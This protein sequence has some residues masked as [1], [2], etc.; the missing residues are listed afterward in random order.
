MTD[1]VPMHAEADILIVDDN[2]A[3][4]E[5]LLALLEDEGYLCLEGMTDPRRVAARVAGRM[6]DLILLDVRMPH[7]SG[8]EVM[9]QLARKEADHGSVI[10][11]FRAIE[12]DHVVDG[13]IEH[14]FEHDFAGLFRG[15]RLERERLVAEF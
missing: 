2:P 10:A 3:N 13:R 1:R 11:G 6:P 8:F 7:L 12:P 4:V 5:L 15:E 14:L 9:E